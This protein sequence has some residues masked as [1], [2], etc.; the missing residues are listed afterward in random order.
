MSEQ[1]AGS[2]DEESETFMEALFAPAR[3]AGFFTGVLLLVLFFWCL[4]R[5][6]PPRRKRNAR[7]ATSVEQQEVEW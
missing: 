2:S 4:L 3:L 6:A 7:G 1:G 5:D